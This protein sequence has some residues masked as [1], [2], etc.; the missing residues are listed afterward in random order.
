MNRPPGWLAA[1]LIAGWLGLAISGCAGEPSEAPP[2]AEEPSQADAVPET[3]Q[4]LKVPDADRTQKREEAIARGLAYLV[5]EQAEDGSWAKGNIGISALCTQALLA[6]GKTIQDPPVRKAVDFLAK[7]QA[8]DGGI[9]DVGLENYTTSLALVV[10][11][12]ADPKTYAPQIEKAKAYLIAHQWD[13]AESIDLGNPWYGGAGYGQHERPDLSNEAFFLEAMHQ[14]GVPK[15]HPLWKKAQVFLSRTQDRS[16]SNDGVFVGTDGGGFIYS[17]HG[18][19]ESKAGTVD[20]PNGNKGLKAYGSMTYAGFKSFVYAGL[21]RDDPRVLAALDW[22]RRHWTFDENPELGQQGLYYYY[23]TAARAL[24]AWGEPTI[25]DARRRTHD[26][27]AEL[28]DAILRRQRENG[29]WFNEAE[30]WFEGEQ[31]PVVPTSY[32]I[33]ALVECRPPA[34]SG[35]SAE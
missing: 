17:P 6:G 8:D 28:S 13:E 35:A 26:W 4:P 29:S 30:R 16:E 18:G 11:V 23:M 34:T 3:P 21:A 10:L 19:G 5:Q 9:R 24:S 33:L 7:Q 2:A 20:L 12:K 32:C 27:R 25:M 22:I 15:D 1:L 14:A 31:V